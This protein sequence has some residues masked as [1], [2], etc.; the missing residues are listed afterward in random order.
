[1]Y[2][3]YSEVQY[4][5]SSVESCLLN[6]WLPTKISK[7]VKFVPIMSFFLILIPEGNFQE[8][9]KGPRPRC[10]AQKM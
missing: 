5:L 6:P 8:P 4:I 9:I 10:N 7:S 2:C 1:M 3:E